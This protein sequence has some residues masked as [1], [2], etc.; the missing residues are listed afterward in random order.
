MLT[1][2]TQGNFYQVLTGFSN[3]AEVTNMVDFSDFKVDPLKV[4]IQIT[5][6][7]DTNAWH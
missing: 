7:Y 4:K 3:N 2:T 5:A 1:R 6:H